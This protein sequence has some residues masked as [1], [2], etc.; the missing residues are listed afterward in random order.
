MK[1]YI[2]V[3]MLIMR[4]NLYRAFGILLGTW[5]VQ[6]VLFFLIMRREM[7]RAD[8]LGLNLERLV[9]K[10]GAVWV[11]AVAFVWITIFLCRMGCAYGTKTGYTLKR[12]SIDEKSVFLCQ[13]AANSLY[14][15]LFWFLE[16]VFAYLLC[17]IV[18]VKIPHTGI[19]SVLLAFYRDPFLHSLLPLAEL[20]LWVRNVVLVLALGVSTAAF[21]WHQRR[22][23][24][25]V[26]VG[27]VVLIT[28]VSFCQ[29]TGSF[30]MNIFIILLMIISISII[31]LNVMG[32]ET[33]D[34]QI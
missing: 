8:V 3:M 15:L 31:S 22:G 32:K 12:L 25:G 11:F 9:E 5:A 17:K 1:K 7:P 30:H 19:Q 27:V 23:K 18:C 4:A 14:F 28:I 2:S 10:S 6:T 16:A 26:G 21:S 29:K 33:E 34:A 20:S 13:S 24:S